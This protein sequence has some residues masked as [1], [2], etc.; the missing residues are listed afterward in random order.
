MPPWRAAQASGPNE[1][2]AKRWSEAAS[3]CVAGAIT[4]SMNEGK[5]S[6]SAAGSIGHAPVGRA[7]A[8]AHRPIASLRRVVSPASAAG[9]R[10]PSNV[11]SQQA[12]Y[13]ALST[14][15]QARSAGR[16]GDAPPY[17]PRLHALTAWARK[18]LDH[19]LERAAVDGHPR[20]LLVFAGFVGKAAQDIRDALDKVIE[21]VWAK[22]RRRGPW[23]RMARD[24]Q[25]GLRRV[26][27]DIEKMIR[28]DEAL[29]RSV[30]CR[31]LVD[32]LQ[33][34][35]DDRQDSMVRDLFGS[36][37][38][39]RLAQ[40]RLSPPVASTPSRLACR[41]GGRVVGAAASGRATRPSRHHSEIGRRARLDRESHCPGSSLL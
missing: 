10:G 38:F 1:Y 14:P 19:D 17:S 40:G 21:E 33:S 5:G 20:K 30:D 27:A 8:D 34:L 26:A 41:P 28:A 39:Q 15:A 36:R 11:R 2:C 24:A 37:A 6:R 22:V 7:A 18:Q 23:R 31:N 29:A 32:A 16:H 25:R 3:R 4:S 13:E 12:P 9:C 35:A